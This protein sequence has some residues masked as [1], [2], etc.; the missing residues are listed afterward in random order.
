MIVF[1]TAALLI[2]LI[3]LVFLGPIALLYK[4]DWIG[5]ESAFLLGGWSLFVASLIGGKMKLKGR[6]FYIF[7]TWAITLPCAIYVSYAHFGKLMRFTIVALLVIVLL[8][9]LLFVYVYFD[10]KKQSRDLHLK[11]IEIPD[12][13]DGTLNYWKQ[14]KELFFFP[15]IGKW[16]EDIYDYNIRVLQHLKENNIELQHAEEFSAEMIKMKNSFLIGDQQKFN[17]KIKDEFLSGIEHQIKI[18]KAN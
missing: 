10:Q 17:R 14:V 15:V 18:W 7:P 9:I 5:E 3:A 12:K 2:A 11:F 8:I 4:I 13:S 1:N 16:N 6:L